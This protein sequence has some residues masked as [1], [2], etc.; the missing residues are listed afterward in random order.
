M[1]KSL[2]RR[3]TILLISILIT[4]VLSFTAISL[5]YS[6]VYRETVL[7]NN[8]SVAERWTEGIDT[9]LN[10]MYEHLYDLLVTLYR[11]A[12]VRPGSLAMDYQN[13]TKI[14]DAINSKIMSSS[15]LNCIYLID[16]ESDLYLYNSNMTVTQPDMYNLK[17]FLRDYAPNNTCGIND[18]RWDVID[19]LEKGYYYKAISIGKYIVGALS[20][21]DYYQIESAT[22]SGERRVCQILSHDHSFT[23]QGNK[24][25]SVEVS[26]GRKSFFYNDYA[27]TVNEQKYADARTVYITQN[28]EFLFRWRISAA[29]MILDSAI[30]VILVF[31]LIRDVNKNVKEPVYK[32]VDSN[33][34]LSAGNLDYK[35]DVSTAGS[36]EFEELYASF[37]DMSDKIGQLTIESYDLK[38]KREQNRLKML[39][40]QVKPHTFL[41]AITTISNMTYTGKPEN[42]RAYI[43]SFAKFTR[44]MLHTKDDWTT[45]GDEITNIDSYVK[46]QKIRFPDSIDI[47]YDVPEEISTVQI[48]YLI[49]FSLVENSFKHAMSLVDTMY[50]TIRAE[51]YE[52]E[53][54]KGVRIIEE[55]NGS[56]FTEE[57]LKQ[58]EESE[59]DDTF[60][61]E[62]LGLT[63]VRYSLN[64]IY[65]RN[66][67][68]RLSNREDK[69]AHIEILIP[70][71]ENTDETISM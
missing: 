49:L 18:R 11:T 39:R 10:S 46:M 69:G 20:N 66:D 25:T 52:E 42:I 24:N 17:L 5:A 64:L 51:K 31:I 61:K 27:V 58:L 57:R 63:N 6:S 22:S 54:F 62:H 53:G 35:I 50:I 4:S 41:N 12:E 47:T 70:E 14:Q 1:K 40:A 45:I 67:L 34:E 32:L 21:C 9:R 38:L 60:T 16:T 48:P 59:N 43:A 37:N 2:I 7:S 36:R 29:F 56:G 23:I 26:G 71:Q 30:C 3:M 33:H 19:I 8:G 68:L 55:D 28:P 13:V 65:G 15:D 44:Y